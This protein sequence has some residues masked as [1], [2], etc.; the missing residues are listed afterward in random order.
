MICPAC[1]TENIQGDDLCVNC[2]TELAGSDKPQPGTRFEQRLLEEHLSALANVELLSVAPE[3]GAAEAVRQ[4]QQRNIGSAV[5]ERDGRV[6]GV[7]TELD[8]LLKLTDGAS[9]DATVDELM[10]ADPVVLRPDDSV[11]VAIHK[12]S[13]GGFRHIPLV[14]GGRAVGIVTARDLFRHILKLLA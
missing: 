12:M 3:L 5:V 13:V 6:V 10:T 8:A 9:P 2:G 4:M 11:A 14:D 7:F 1:G